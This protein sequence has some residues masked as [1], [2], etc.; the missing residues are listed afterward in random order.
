MRKTGFL[1]LLAFFSTVL[2]GQSGFQEKEEFSLLTLYPDVLVRTRPEISA[3]VLAKLESKIFL[4]ATGEVSDHT[5]TISIRGKA[6]TANWWEVSTPYGPGWVFGGLVEKRE[7]ISVLLPGI[8]DGEKDQFPSLSKYLQ[9][10]WFTIYREGVKYKAVPSS[11]AL[12]KEKDVV[13]NEMRDSV[14]DRNVKEPMFFLRGLRP[15]PSI[16][17]P[18]KEKSLRENTRTEHTFY[19]GS[20]RYTLKLYA[21]S[22]AMDPNFPGGE[23]FRNVGFR[24]RE[25]EKEKDL[26]HMEESVLL[27]TLA[28]VGDL[29]G[30]GRLD[31]LWN[32]YKHTSVSCLRL[33]L[34]SLDQRDSGYVKIDGQCSYAC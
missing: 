13:L 26:F 11:L 6:I 32:F 24:I 14:Y 2:L 27:P 8:Y 20:Y 30:D 4:S 28:W 15:I 1:F 5:D 18:K 12:K 25:G 7:K 16:S 3:G 34:S 31:F 33:Y 23:G 29:D 17:I 19:F 9:G 22:L 21:E 10:S